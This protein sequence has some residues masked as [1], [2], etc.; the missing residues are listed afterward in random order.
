MNAAELRA[1]T[2]PAPLLLLLRGRHQRPRSEETS[3]VQT[4]NVQ[5]LLVTVQHALLA[6]PLT[7]LPLQHLSSQQASLAPPLLPPLLPHNKR[8]IRGQMQRRAEMWDKSS[9]QCM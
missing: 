2:S 4:I 9:G 3:G 6:L 8:G 7:G 1:Q 5:N